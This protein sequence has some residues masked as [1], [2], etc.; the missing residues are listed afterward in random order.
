[1]KGDQ[2]ALL[3]A[4]AEMGLKLCV[5]LPDQSMEITNMI[6]STTA[7]AAEALVCIPLFVVVI[8]HNYLTKFEMV[9]WGFWAYLFPGKHES[10]DESEE[11]E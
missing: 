1:M 2:A 6:F 4:F 3:S 11:K 10:H 5:D 9:T 7:P 8:F